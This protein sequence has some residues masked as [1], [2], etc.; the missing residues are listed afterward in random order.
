[1]TEP[2]WLHTWRETPVIMSQSHPPTARARPGRG[3]GFLPA[4]PACQGGLACQIKEQRRL[5]LWAVNGTDNVGSIDWPM[6][7][8]T[9]AH[10]E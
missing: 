4:V 2:G 10:P 9:E 5:T 8:R 6:R 1:M 7:L 3:H